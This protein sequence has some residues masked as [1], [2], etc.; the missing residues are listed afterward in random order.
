MSTNFINC[1]IITVVFIGVAINTTVVYP[2]TIDPLSAIIS[3]QQKL[4]EQE[5]LNKQIENFK[6]WEKEREK[7]REK[8]NADKT[9]LETANNCFNVDKIILEN[10]SLLSKKNIAKNTVKY[11]NTCISANEI[12]ELITA[13]SNS[14]KNKGYITTQIYIKKQ[15]LKSGTLIL[16]V[17]E[18]KVEDIKFGNN[19]IA[20]KITNYFITPLSKNDILNVKAIDQTTE[21]LNY[22]PSYNYKTNIDAGS[23]AGLSK[24]NI[25]GTKNFPISL[26]AETDTLGQK[27]TG[28]NRYTIGSRVDN[29]LK[30]GDSFNLKYISTKGFFNSDEIRYPFTNAH[31]S[32]STS[33]IISWSMPLQWARLGI[34]SSY[35]SYLTIIQGQLQSFKST[36]NTLSNSFFVNG[37]IFRNKFVKTTL[38][39]T[40]NLLSSKHYINDTYIKTQSR[41]LANIELG[42]MNNLYTSYGGFFHKLTYI[43]G[44]N[45]FGTS[46]DPTNAT[47]HGQFDSFR[48]YQLYSVKTDKI[49]KGKLPLSF[50]N[51]IDTQYSFQDI[52]SQNQFVL[53]GFYSIRGF[54]DVNIYG[55]SGILTRNDIDFALIDYIKPT[56]KFTQFLTN[57]GKG[58]FT[59]GGFFDV[60][61]ASS[62]LG[63]NTTAGGTGAGNLSNGNH[64]VLAG[65]GYKIDYTSKYFQTSVI[66][67]YPI[68][69]PNN[70]KN[71]VKK[72]DDRI[73]YVTLRS[74]W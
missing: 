9:D 68:I 1:V 41:N 22:I 40:L 39:S 55:A 33:Y 31:N 57:N 64:R 21:N 71:S 27:Y 19:S 67:A 38:I 72:N 63:S 18:G 8:E 20:D 10:N 15:N 65:A 24:I 36:G 6:N 23:K 29:P 25:S 58:G 60:G 42:I 53:G 47:Y 14:Y 62:D 48:F 5:Q 74:N 52:Y 73:I 56:N 12:N 59:F 61:K 34:N 43:R 50:Q 11:I 49:F 16:D 69:Y 35:S 4:I 13:F 37:V 30:L 54:R 26:Y 3:Q 28:Y 70:L 17:I 51:T 45:I 66:V 46:A 2:E 7:E 44:L 32:Y